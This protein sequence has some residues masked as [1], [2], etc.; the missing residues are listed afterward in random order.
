LPVTI[1]SV[2]HV[3][4]ESQLLVLGGTI[5]RLG[6]IREARMPLGFGRYSS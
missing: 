1:H 2:A 6:G 5:D 3:N 4:V